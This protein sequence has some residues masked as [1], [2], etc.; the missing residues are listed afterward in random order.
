MRTGAIFARGSCRALKWMALVGVVFALGVGSAIAQPAAPRNFEVTPAQNDSNTATT[1]AVMLKWTTPIQGATVTSYEWRTAAVSSGAWQTAT[2]NLREVTTGQLAA[3]LVHNFELRAVHDTDGDGSPGEA[4]EISEAVPAS[5]TAIGI[6]PNPSSVTAEAGNESVALKWTA[7]A[8]SAQEID[9]YEYRYALTA[10]IDNAG[11]TSTRDASVAV[12][13]LQNGVEYTFQV[14]AVNRAGVSETPG[15]AT[16]TPAGTP[17]APRNLQ[18]DTTGGHGQVVLDWDPPSSNGGL[19]IAQVT[20]YEYR[21]NGTAWRRVGTDATVTTVTLDSLTPHLLHIFEVRAANVMGVSEDEGDWARTEATPTGPLQ[22]PSEPRDFVGIAGDKMVMLTWSAPLNNGGAGI[23]GYDYRMD[24]GDWQLGNTDLTRTVGDLTNGQN[25]SFEVRARNSEGH[26]QAA[27]TTA[28]PNPQLPGMP[29]GLTASAGDGQVILSWS[30]PTTGGAPTGYEVRSMVDGRYSGWDDAASMTGH[31]VMD[32][33]NGTE[34][35][36]EVRAENDRGYGPAASATA[37]PMAAPTT[38]GVPQSLTASAGDG[39]VTLSWTAPATGSAPTAYDYRVIGAGVEGQWRYTDNGTGTEQTVSDLTNGT[40]YT[41]EVRAWHGALASAAASVKATPMAPDPGAQVTVKEVQAATSVAESG[42]LDVTVVA[43]VPAGAKGADDKVAPIPLRDVHVTFPTTDK[44]IKDGEEAEDGE[45]R[46]LGLPDSLRWKEIARTEKES[47]QEFEF[48]VAVGQD[49]DAEDEKFQIEVRINGEGAKSKVITIDDAEEQKFVLTLESDH[50]EKN[51]IEEGDSGTLKL[52]ADPH[53]TGSLDVKLVLHPDDPTK[54]SKYTLDTTSASLAAGGSVTATVSAEA[55]GDR[56]PD[57]VTVVA[58]TTGALGN[59]EMLPGAELEITVADINALPAVEAMIV[60]DKGKAL[61]PQPESVMEGETVEVMLTVVD[62]DGKAM[63]AVEDLS[64][65]LMP[66]S[67]SSADYRLSTHPIMIEKG[68]KSSA[69]VELMLEMDDDIG[70]EML[71][72]DASVAGDA[73]IGTDTRAVNNVLSLAI[74]DGTQKLV[75]A[76]TEE[77]VQ[78][79]IYAAKE[80]GA[81]D[82]MTFTPGEMIEVMGNDLFSAAEGVTLSYT[83]ESDM[84]GVASTSVGGGKVMVTAVGEGMAHITITAHA[85]MPS[86]AKPLPQTD[87][88]EAS[89]IFPVEVGLEALSIMLS[90]PEDMNVAEG[91]SAMVTATANRAATEDVTV[92]LMRDREMSSAGDADFMAEPIVIEAGEMMGSTMIMA[93]EDNMMEDMEELVLY[94]MTEGMAGEVTGEV[95]LYLW[96]A[97]VPALPVIAQLL[98]AAFLAV[99]G[100]RRYR[101][102]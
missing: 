86:G 32:L 35:T 21:V 66:S 58:Y 40:E 1:G 30:A 92:M 59:D 43:T 3:G 63:A 62:K 52:V 64:V 56:E 91:M 8:T 25:Y 27:R 79:A 85:N 37:T 17:S 51:T 77:E 98:L 24:G 69:A 26:G 10:G 65:S 34:Y 96:D 53:K 82:D 80:A 28:T 12:S 14:R 99:G 60:D 44:S 88:R 2:A 54:S 81:G 22:V 38:P 94:G 7:T 70:M 100:Y 45:L 78:A 48:R 49:L 4:G 101:R 29:Q 23:T 87:P 33:T 39:R 50:K 36:F 95:K 83:A 76:K 75:Y 61:D 47:E 72:F 46:V 67:G 5:V 31:T 41:F 84:S 102:R 93:V 11:W 74:E 19:P 6:P 68:K 9:K 20:R 18:A 57:S 13:N 16:A 71:V 15:A 42:G 90:G 55:D 97:A 73:K 89:V